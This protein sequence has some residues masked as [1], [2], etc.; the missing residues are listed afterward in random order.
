M[1]P[2]TLV[3]WKIVRFW[4]HS[5]A[6]LECNSFRSTLW[7][8][9]VHKTMSGLKSILQTTNYIWDLYRSI[10]LLNEAG[11]LPYRRCWSSSWFSGAWN[12]SLCKLAH[13]K[14]HWRLTACLFFFSLYHSL[15]LA[16]WDNARVHIVYVNHVVVDKA[17]TTV[18]NSNPI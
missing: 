3:V 9:T 15:T 8:I 14:V 16:P 6:R 7:I 2:I 5:I 11:I 17:R 1:C 18:V 10:F 12:R 13:L 4:H